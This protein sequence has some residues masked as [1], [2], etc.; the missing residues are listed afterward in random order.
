M[1]RRIWLP[2]VAYYKLALVQI[3]IYWQQHMVGKEVF[4]RKSKSTPLHYTKCPN[5]F[6]TY[7]PNSFQPKFGKMVFSVI[8]SS[9]VFRNHWSLPHRQN[10]SIKYFQFLEPRQLLLSHY[11][12]SNVRLSKDIMWKYFGNWKKCL[13][14]FTTEWR[15][16]PLSPCMFS[17]HKT[18]NQCTI[19][20]LSP[21]CPGR[22]QFLL[23][24]TTHL[25]YWNWSMTG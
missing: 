5:H 3:R 23:E 17:C 2:L 10:L 22:L 14:C 11:R 13:F 16:L 21:S 9:A 7:L 6:L 4:G 1:Y 15:R 12:Q 20:N 18:F 24:D 19:W 25:T 8:K